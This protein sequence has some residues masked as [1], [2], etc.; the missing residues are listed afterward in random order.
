MNGKYRANDDLRKHG[1]E[2]GNI[3][4]MKLGNKFRIV[5]LIVDII[6]LKKRRITRP[7][8]RIWVKR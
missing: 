5:L 3:S 1:I 6:M 8:E 7:N 4:Q 2:H